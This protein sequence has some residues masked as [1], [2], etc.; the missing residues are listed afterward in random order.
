MQ[1]EDEEEVNEDNGGNLRLPKAGEES[2]TESIC[3]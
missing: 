2:G 1:Q 3:A